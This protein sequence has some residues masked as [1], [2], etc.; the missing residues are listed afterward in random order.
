[1]RVRS[2]LTAWAEIGCAAGDGLL[3]D[4]FAT[5]LAGGGAVRARYEKVRR[6]ILVAAGLYGQPQYAPN[7]AV[8]ALDLFFG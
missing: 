4:S 2:S 3:L 7:L 1:V 8:H 5:Y 6:E